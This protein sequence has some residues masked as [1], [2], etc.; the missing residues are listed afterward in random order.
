[1]VAFDAVEQSV[2]NPTNTVRGVEHFRIMGGG[3]TATS[4]SP[5]ATG[6]GEVAV[7]KEKNF[8]T[9]DTEST[10]EEKM[11]NREICPFGGPSSAR[12]WNVMPILMGPGKK[13]F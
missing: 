5:T 3:D 13:R 2:T 7:R 1:M 4:L 8:T 9:E 12:P 10:E 11:L 6:A